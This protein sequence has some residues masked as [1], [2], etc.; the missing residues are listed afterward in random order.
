[1]NVMMFELFL[2]SKNYQNLY[3]ILSFSKLKYLFENNNIKP[4]SAGNGFI[5]FT[6]D[7]MMNSYLGDDPSSFFKL[8]INASKLS[9]KYKIKPFSYIS[10]TKVRFDEREERVK[11]TIHNAFDYIDK[12][13]LIKDRI[14][15]LKRSFRGSHSPSDWFTTTN[16]YNRE[17][18]NIPDIIRYVKEHSPCDIYVQSGTKIEKDDEYVRS[19]IDYE[20]VKVVFKYDIWYRGFFKSDRIKYGSVDTFITSTGDK[21]K[22]IV[23]GKDYPKTLDLYDK[24]PDIDV[25]YKNKIIDGIECNPYLITF[26][27]TPDSYYLEDIRRIDK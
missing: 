6:R 26:R 10:Y 21:I 16:K 14:E 3:H 18:N 9:T 20:L 13:I 12:I 2:E 1:M 8:E 27:E 17:F 23:I 7:K 24:R 4:F 19:L 11:G 5:S 25:E 15:E 22:N